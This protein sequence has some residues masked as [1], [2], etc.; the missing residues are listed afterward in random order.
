MET[1][2]ELLG[3]GCSWSGGLLRK[4]TTSM[5]DHLGMGL[6]GSSAPGVGATY[7]ERMAPVCLKI[8]AH[9]HISVALLIYGNGC[10]SPFF[11]FSKLCVYHCRSLLSFSPCLSDSNP[12]SMAQKVA[13]RCSIWMPRN[14]SFS[15]FQIK[16]AHGVQVVLESPVASRSHVLPF[17][18]TT[19]FL[20]ISCLALTTHFVFTNRLGLI[21]G[22]V[23][24]NRLAL[25]TVFVFTTR[26]AFT[27][28]SSRTVLMQTRA[29]ISRKRRT[30][31][32]RALYN[33]CSLFGRNLVAW[34]HTKLL[35]IDKEDQFFP[36]LQSIIGTIITE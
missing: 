6:H 8:W 22:F 17:M 7:A 11:V 23:F 26:S 4:G 34:C 2:E 28:S 15:Y 29:R 36:I 19:A 33:R 10:T 25:I 35:T 14:R 12:M 18:L 20:L 30:D 24:T 9:S 31:G 27:N 32:P 5:G 16:L 21:V 13:P 3:L 1:L